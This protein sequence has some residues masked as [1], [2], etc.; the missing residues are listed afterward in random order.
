[1]L[2]VVVV[3][4]RVLVIRQTKGRHRGAVVAVAA[5]DLT[6]AAAAVAAFRAAAEIVVQAAVVGV[7]FRAPVA[8]GVVAVRRGVT[9]ALLVA[10]TPDLVDLVAE[11][12]FM[13]SAIRL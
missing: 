7:V 1:L 9:V 4:E 11:Q 6:E 5:Q 13:L 8:P 3:A 12:V 2:G 10:L